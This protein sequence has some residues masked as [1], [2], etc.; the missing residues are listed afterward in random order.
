MSEF[1][2]IKQIR[3]MK[4]NDFNGIFYMYEVNFKLNHLT[5]RTNTSIVNLLEKNKLNIKNYVELKKLIGDFYANILITNITLK[6]IYD[7]NVKCNVKTEKEVKFL[8]L[9]SDSDFQKVGFE[10]ETVTRLSACSS[11]VASYMYYH[12]NSVVTISDVSK[13]LNESN[14]KKLL[15]YIELAFTYDMSDEQLE[16]YKKYGNGPLIRNNKHLR[17]KFN[18]EGVRDD[19]DN[20]TI[21]D[22]SNG[23]LTA[24]NNQTDIPIAVMAESVKRKTKKGE[25]VI[26]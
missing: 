11:N 6:M 15:N 18:E 12:R 4:E 13:F 25:C 9:M 19:I 7:N 23:E 1:E 2:V 3:N 8:Q 26:I 5:V 10:N 21:V 17:S 14:S 24:F 20:G 16:S 22:K